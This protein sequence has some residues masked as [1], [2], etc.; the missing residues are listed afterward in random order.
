M[1]NRQ[2]PEQKRRREKNKSLKVGDLVKI[3]ETTPLIDEDLAGTVG[4]IIAF[5]ESGYPKGLTGH[6][7]G[8]IMYTVAALG[9]NIKLFEDEVEVIA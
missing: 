3:N 9:R 2:K 7:R 6:A 8:S 1:A 5:S 4:M